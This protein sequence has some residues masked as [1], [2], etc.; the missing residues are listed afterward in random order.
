MIK[1][2]AFDQ[3]DTALM[4]DGKP[5]PAGLGAIE[6]ALDRGIVV[7][8]VSGR[9]ID[10]ST[11]PFREAL[12]LFERLYVIA[13]NGSIIL[14]PA[15]NGR[16]RLLFEQ[17]LPPET[18]LDIL[19]Y[20]ETNGL[21]F[22]YSWLRAEPEGVRDSVIANR[23]SESIERIIDQNGAQIQIDPGIVRLLR[24]GAYPS[25]PKL[26]ILPGIDRREAVF[27]D[28]RAKYDSRLYLVKTSPDRIEVMHPEVNKKAGVEFIAR[29]HGFSLRDVMAV[30]DGENDLP[31]LF[32]AGLG[33]IMG[34]A[35]EPVRRE[36]A[37]RGLVIG[38]PNDAD[39]FARAVRRFA[40]DE[41]GNQD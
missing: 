2:I 24:D 39:G 3:D 29:R 5:S 12:P 23:H 1:L 11:E 32:S 20:I 36:A 40:L 7:A 6:D 25:P 4:P 26:L 31:M 10:R 41:T 37:S 14:S 13:N 19:E 34:N 21:N 17:R 15:E 38:P 35:A 28:L 18:L 22:V 33:V 27:E 9:N 16:R 30:G 8:S